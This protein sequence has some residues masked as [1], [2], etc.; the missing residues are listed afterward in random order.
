MHFARGAMFCVGLIAVSAA[1]QT[2]TRLSFDLERLELDPSAVSS[3]IVQTGR[4]L[5][6]HEFRIG[7]G[8]QYEKKPLVASMDNQ[9]LSAVIRDRLL[10]D[11]FAA[12]ALTSRFELSLQ[13]PIVSYQQGELLPASFGV[14]TP[15]QS[16]LGTPWVSA[17]VGLLQSAQIDLG[18]ELAVGVPLGSK[19]ALGG[20]GQFS[21]LPRVSLGR[22]F[23][24]LRFSTQVGVLLRRNQN[25]G[26][27]RLGSHFGWDTSIGYTASA[28]KPEII[29]RTALPFQSLPSSFEILAA[30]RLPLFVGIEAFA[31]GGPGFGGLVGTPVFRALGGLAYS[32]SMAPRVSPCDPGQTHTPE[33][34]PK[35]DDDNDGIL[36]EDDLCPL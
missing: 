1:A 35:L 27:A 34:C 23:Q 30:A 7:A 22:Q 36:N 24:D 15:A 19:E 9:V 2:T 6:E 16:G 26:N 25:L 29:F 28:L 11:V 21:L 3:L 14:A 17:R 18:A 8:L 13:V 33:E 20:D 31:L 5:P 4:T 12:Y 32:P 10:T